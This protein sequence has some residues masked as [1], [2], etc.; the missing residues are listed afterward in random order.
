MSAD[1]DDRVGGSNVVTPRAVLFDAAGVLTVPFSFELVEPAVAAGADPE[2]LVEVLYP[3]FAH[4]GDGTSMG[5]R[6][7]RGEVTLEDFFADL[8]PAEPHCRAVVDP[9]SPTFFGHQWAG[10]PV[11]HD[12][13]REVS[14]VGLATALVSNNVRE[15]QPVWDR[16]VPP[17]LPFDARLFSWELGMRKPEPDIYLE[18]LDRLRVR[19]DEA[20]FLDDFPAMV[21]GARAVG[22]TAIEVTDKHQAIAEARALLGW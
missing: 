18:A 15:W 1:R 6:L 2:L 12:F 16:V 3:I 9:A 4:A 10:D 22:M 7:E 13:V 11:M 21:E 5:N 8:G 14:A 20:I 19:A 17:D